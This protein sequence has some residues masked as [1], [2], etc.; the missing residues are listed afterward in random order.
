MSQI[1]LGGLDWEGLSCGL[2][3]IVIPPLPI[4][5]K[6]KAGE[7]NKEQG[8]HVPQ[9]DCNYQRHDCSTSLADKSGYCLV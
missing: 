6:S 7:K 4:R 8:R 9:P 5:S 3:Y 1:H 2:R